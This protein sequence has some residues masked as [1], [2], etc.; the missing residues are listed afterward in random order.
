MHCIACKCCNESNSVSPTRTR[1][2]AQQ[3]PAWDHRS[4]D[5]AGII[6]LQDDENGE[7]CWRTLAEQAAKEEDP[8]ELARL[9]FQIDSL[10]DVIEKRMGEL[11]TVGSDRKATLANS[12]KARC[13][14]I[15]C[16]NRLGA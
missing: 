14:R 2:Q 8:R 12:A 11:D 15:R 1:R 4:S 10:L 9:V 5:R 13:T 7:Q 6:T 3:G 16:R